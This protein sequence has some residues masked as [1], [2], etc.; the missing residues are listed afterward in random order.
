MP[1]VA[2]IRRGGGSLPNLSHKKK[3][4]RRECST[5]AVSGRDTDESEGCLYDVKRKR[6]RTS[7]FAE[8]QA[9]RNAYYEKGG[10]GKAFV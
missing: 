1:S 8:T 4:E 10:P 3:G 7:L 9:R 5:V 2:K 6:K